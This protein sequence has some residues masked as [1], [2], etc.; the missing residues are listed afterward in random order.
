MS[1]IYSDTL[2]RMPRTAVKRGI[3]N[4]LEHVAALE[5]K[6]HAE[7]AARLKAERELRVLRRVRFD[8]AAQTESVRQSLKLIGHTYPKKP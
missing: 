7:R 4:R 5:A 8:L 6:A 1:H 3:V 2:P